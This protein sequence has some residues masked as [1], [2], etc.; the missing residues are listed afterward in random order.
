VTLIDAAGDEHA[1]ASFGAG[2][3]MGV[4]S[5]RPRV[6]PP[7]GPWR[8]RLVADDTAGRIRV[9][10]SEPSRPDSVGPGSVPGS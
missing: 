2:T 9:W 10:T 5:S 4:A 7:S 6:A 8:L 3:T 1:L